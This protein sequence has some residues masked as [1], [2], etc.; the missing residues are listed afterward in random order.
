[1]CVKFEQIVN[2]PRRQ[3]IRS[4]I[5]RIHIH[6]ISLGVGIFAG[7]HRIHNANADLSALWVVPAE[8][9]PGVVTEISLAGRRIRMQ[10]GTRQV[11]R[12]D[13]QIRPCRASAS[14]PYASPVG[15]PTTLSTAALATTF[16]PSITSMSAPG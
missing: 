10:C 7:R 4:L 2:H 15:L 11:Y 13:D 12:R 9:V 8:D 16:G 6:S 14:G 3:R 1:M 5:L